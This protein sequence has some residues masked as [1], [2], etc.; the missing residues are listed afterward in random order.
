MAND[1]REVN[2][3][4]SAGENKGE[5]AAQL[6]NPQT[7]GMLDREIEE[8]GKQQR[9]LG[10]MARLGL[11]ATNFQR[12]RLLPNFK[13]QSVLPDG[14]PASPMPVANLFGKLNLAD[15]AKQQS[16]QPNGESPASPEPVV[17]RLSFGGSSVME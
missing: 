10:D 14:E 15:T 2:A 12:P 7:P 9:L 17:R 13:T 3:P 6:E 4:I 16:G 1:R 8:G 5:G 11:L